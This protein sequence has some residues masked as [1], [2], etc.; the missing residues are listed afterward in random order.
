ML[1][2]LLSLKPR[3]SPAEL[4]LQKTAARELQ[5]EEAP[6]SPCISV[7]RMSDQ[8]GLCEGCFR[9]LEE[10]TGWGHRAPEAKRDMWRLIQQRLQAKLQA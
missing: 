10:I 5:K 3:L 1:D 7:C 6:L 8:T 2:R 9:T 4:R